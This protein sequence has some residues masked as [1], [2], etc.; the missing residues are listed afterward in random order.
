MIDVT[1]LLDKKVYPKDLEAWCKKAMLQSGLNEKD[2]SYAAD[3]FTAADTRGIHSHGTRQIRQLMNNVKDGRID[4]NASPSID[5]DSL[6]AV[7]LDGNNAMPTTNAVEGMQLAIDRAKKYGIG[8]VGVKNSSHIGALSYYPIMAAKQGCIGIA[9]TNT[10]PWMTVPGGK[11]PIM[12]TNPIA[13]AVPNGTENPIFL[14]I[15]TSSVAVTKILSMKAVGKKLPE[16]WLVDENG[17]PTD[18]PTNYPEKGALLP[19]AMHKGY[20]LAL[21]VEILVSSLSGGAWLSHINCWLNDKPEFANEGHSFIAINVDALA[22]EQNFIERLNAMTSEIVNSP[23]AEG[24]KIMLPGDIEHER[25]RK[26]FESGLSLPDYVLVNLR[27]LSQDIKDEEG[28][29]KL[30]F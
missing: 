29:N 14:D 16:K 5:R 23:K 9:M 19:M 4:P 22:G 7:I 11:G 18:D 25:R 15:A 24:S 26:A 8:F 6:G 2:A 3:V 27:G 20:G 10:D 21:L 28:F 30:F 13:Y 12:G 17:V 1:D